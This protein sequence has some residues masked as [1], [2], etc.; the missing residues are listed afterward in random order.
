MAECHTPVVESLYSF[1]RE[2]A[3]DRVVLRPSLLRRW[4]AVP[5][6]GFGGLF[7]VLALRDPS[8][9]MGGLVF[10]SVWSAGVLVGSLSGFTSRV[11]LDA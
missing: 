11:I 7:W 8:M 4:I 6:V 9:S 10:L 5:M 1:D 3:E 2:V